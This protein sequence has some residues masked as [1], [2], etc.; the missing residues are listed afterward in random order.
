M[1]Y[2]SHSLCGALCCNLLRGGERMPEAPSHNAPLCVLSSPPLLSKPMPFPSFLSWQRQRKEALL[3]ALFVLLTQLRKRGG[4]G[5]QGKRRKEGGLALLSCLPS[6]LWAAPGGLAREKEGKK[7]GQEK[8]A[9]AHTVD[10]LLRICS[11][12]HVRST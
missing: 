5:E 3:E 10:F 2:R 11:T 7:R 1:Y 12:R 8:L 4:R 9:A 6:L